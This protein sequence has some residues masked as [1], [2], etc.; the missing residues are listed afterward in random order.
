MN[1]IYLHLIT[2]FRWLHFSVARH[3]CSTSGAFYSIQTCFY[4]NHVE[5][6]HGVQKVHFCYNYLLRKTLCYLLFRWNMCFAVLFEKEISTGLQQCIWM[7]KRMIN[8]GMIQDLYGA[9]M[10]KWPY[11]QTKPAQL[12][13]LNG[14]AAHDA[15]PNLLQGFVSHNKG[16][17]VVRGC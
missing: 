9:N 5:I 15:L 2:P 14:S 12:A 8:H 17:W 16:S 3:A 13:V 4:Y 7:G 6:Q 10:S 1:P 11:L